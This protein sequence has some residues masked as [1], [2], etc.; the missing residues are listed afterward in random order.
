MMLLQWRH[1]VSEQAFV[2]RE[3]E[4]SKLHAF[5]D[6]A[7]AGHG[8]C[9]RPATQLTNSGVNRA[10]NKSVQPKVVEHL[11]LSLDKRASIG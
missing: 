5:L 1:S 4:L 7:L 6:T 10:N 9:D 2:A 3:R 11:S 8:Q